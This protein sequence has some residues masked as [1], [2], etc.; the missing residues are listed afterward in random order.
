MLKPIRNF[1]RLIS[2][3]KGA[4]VTLAIWLVIVIGMVVFAP[5]ASDYEGSSE[6]A[7]IFR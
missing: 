1:V 3:K 4:I 7:S 2:N 5:S 6:E